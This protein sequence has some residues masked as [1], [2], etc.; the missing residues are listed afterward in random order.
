MYPSRELLLKS[1]EIFRRLGYHVIVKS[2]K[3]DPVSDPLLQGDMYFEDLNHYPCN[4][5]EL[6]YVCD[7]VLYFSSSIN[8]EC[9]ILNKPYIDIKVDMEKDRFPYLN[10]KNS[11]VIGINYINM[12]NLEAIL[13]RSVKYFIHNKHTTDK[14]FLPIENGSENIIEWTKTFSINKV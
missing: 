7:I 9:T 2:R 14:R 6:I 1:Y 11:A 3:Q 5:L 12:D 4:S 13:T 8:E 10:G